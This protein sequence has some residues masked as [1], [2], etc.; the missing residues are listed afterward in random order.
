[1]RERLYEF[2]IP[3]AFIF[4]ER[5]LPDPD[6]ERLP[7]HGIE[8]FTVPHAGHDMPFDN[9]SGFAVTIARTLGVKTSSAGSG[10]SRCEGEGPGFPGPSQ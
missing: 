10:S 7:E 1:M 8:V 4:G 9:P 5:G 6:T 2:Q 3:R